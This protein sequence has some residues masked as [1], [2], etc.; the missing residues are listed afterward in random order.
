MS[1]SEFHIPPARLSIAGNPQGKHVGCRFFGLPFFRQV[2]KGNSPIKGEKRITIQE[3]IIKKSDANLVS[4]TRKIPHYYTQ[5]EHSPTKKP[6]PHRHPTHRP[7][8]QTHRVTREVWR[9]SDPLPRN[10]NYRNPRTEKPADSDRKT[11]Q[12]RYS[13]LHQPQRSDLRYPNAGT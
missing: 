10:R 3:K 5:H 9:N 13:H 12:L 8:Q 4:Y 6:H 11:K 1:V 7:G 2:K